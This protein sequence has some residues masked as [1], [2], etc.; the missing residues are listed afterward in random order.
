MKNPR[1]PRPKKTKPVPTL[2]MVKLLQQKLAALEKDAVKFD[3]GVDLAGQRLRQ[4][5]IE[6][7]YLIMNVRADIQRVRYYREA[8]KAMAGKKN[9]IDNLST[10]ETKY[11]TIA[12]VVQLQ[13]LWR[14]TP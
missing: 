10:K 1:T 13:E 9:W 12:E 2:A 3:K 11:G 7:K 5:L 6:A 14:S 4:G 8:E